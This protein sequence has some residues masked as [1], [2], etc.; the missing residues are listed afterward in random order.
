M[1][2]NKMYMLT[3]YAA[4]DASVG[5]SDLAPPPNPLN[6]TFLTNAPTATKRF[7]GIL[8]IG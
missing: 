7:L 3:G 5:I 1:A 4:K 6:G 8:V 2:Y